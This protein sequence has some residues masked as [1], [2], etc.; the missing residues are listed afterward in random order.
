MAKSGEGAK[1]KL[2][3]TW[4]AMLFLLV[5]AFNSL[6]LL[7]KATVDA[8]LL[9]D[10]FLLATAMAA[11]GLRTHVGAIRQ[12]GVKP[13]LLAALLFAWLVF[14]GLAINLGVTRLLG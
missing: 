12:A 1:S 6:H 5:G 9:L 3:I 8:I 4:F 10:V 11:L 14:G 2:V 7:P 13:L